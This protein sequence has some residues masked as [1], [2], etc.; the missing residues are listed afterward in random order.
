VPSHNVTVDLKDREQTRRDARRARTEL[1]FLRMWSI[2][3][4]QI[5]PILDAMAPDEAAIDRAAR[6][7]L[8]ARAK[9]W[10]PIEIEGHLHDRASYRYHWE[11]LER[12]H[13]AGASIPDAARTAFFEG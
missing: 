11:Q 5:D 3:P 7:L 2:H 12:A 6:I 8:A 4:D 10:G 9:D 13:L 1:G